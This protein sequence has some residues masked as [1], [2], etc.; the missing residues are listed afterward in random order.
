VNKKK[1]NSALQYIFFLGLGFVLL[2]LSFHK[3]DMKVLWNEIKSANYFWMFLALVFAILSHIARAARWNLLINSMGYNT[4][5]SSTFFSVM[6]GYMANTAVPRMGE[7]IRCGVLSKKEKIPF[8]ALFGTVISERLFDMFVL[9]LIIF[10]VILFQVN[11]VGGFLSKIFQPLFHSA[12]NNFTGLIIITFLILFFFV[13]S[14]W[15][16]FKFR[17]KIKNLSF[18]DKTRLFFDGLWNGIKTVLKMKQKW[19]FIFYSIVIWFF[20]ALM[21]WLPLKMFPET[22]NLTFID[23]ITLLAISS[24]GVI[25][26]VPGGIGAYHIIVKSFLFKVFNIN[27]I[28]AGSFAAIN[29]A[30]QTLLN[31][32]TGIISYFLLGILSQKQKPANE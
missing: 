22:S 32:L 16:L 10:F 21:T 9:L 6:V 25:A 7:F 31:V 15:L 18:Y 28:V 2:W 12:K 4:R 29:H 20:Y 24:L 5:L 19:L 30:G 8:N 26:P 17:E 23:G 11:V 13:I 1:V 14:I 3:L 27:Q